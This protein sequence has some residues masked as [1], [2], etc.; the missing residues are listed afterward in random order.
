LPDAAVANLEEEMHRSNLGS[1]T[2]GGESMA[3][4]AHHKKGKVASKSTGQKYQFQIMRSTDVPE[5][6]IPKFAE[7]EYWLKYFPPLAIVRIFWFICL[8]WLS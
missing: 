7:P 4:S 1:G 3:N 6:E 5:S 2:I 8:N